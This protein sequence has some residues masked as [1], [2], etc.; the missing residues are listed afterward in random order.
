MA[1]LEEFRQAVQALY[2]S[3]P[4]AQQQ[5]NVWLYAFSSTPAAWEAGLAMLEPGLPSWG[6]FFS[7][8]LLL[9][10]TRTEWSKLQAEHRAQLTAAVG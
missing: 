3:D 2:G 4:V 8:N 7:A 1:A 9:N 10:K 5:A 6:Q